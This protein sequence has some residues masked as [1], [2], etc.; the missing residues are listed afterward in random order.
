MTYPSWT[1]LLTSL[2]GILLTILAKPIFRFI[3]SWIRTREERNKA[4]PRPKRETAIFFPAFVSVCGVVFV[5]L[6]L[7]AVAFPEPAPSRPIVS[8]IAIGGGALSIIGLLLLVFGVPAYNHVMKL[9]D[10]VSQ[11]LERQKQDLDRFKQLLEFQLRSSQDRQLKLED[12]CL[13]L[14]ARVKE[15]ESEDRAPKKQ[16][17]EQLPPQGNLAFMDKWSVAK[18]DAELKRLAGSSQR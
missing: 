7:L 16:G 14:L 1:S 13:R 6:A 8:A 18:R 5:G 4:E 11:N 12:L 15:L 9:D 2:G 3:R 17:E 10:R